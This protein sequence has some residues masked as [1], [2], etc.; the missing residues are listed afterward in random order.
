MNVYPMNQETVLSHLTAEQRHLHHRLQT[1]H[2]LFTTAGDG[3]PTTEQLKQLRVELAQLR[4][5]LGELYR[6]EEQDGLLEEAVAQRPVIGPRVTALNQEHPALL[7]E[8]D[9]L[10]TFC[11]AQPL[12]RE[13][14]L[15]LGEQYAELKRKLCEHEMQSNRLVQQGF[16]FD[17]Q[18]LLD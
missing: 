6:R 13:M 15:L 18:E 10:M 9:R 16:N 4:E 11:Q 7:A 17:C 12:T 14:W 5:E 8:L 2:K 3:L 1:I